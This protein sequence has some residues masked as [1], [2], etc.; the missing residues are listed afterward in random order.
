MASNEPR[1][2]KQ[3]ALAAKYSWQGVRAAWRFEASFRLE[4]YVA[5]VLVPLAP[6]LART[7]LETALLVGSVLLV[8]AMELMNAGLEAIT[9][10]T[11]PE[12]NEL[13]G[14][15]K[16]LGSA[17]VSACMLIALLLWLAVLADR[18]L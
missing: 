14:R 6:W 2:L 5:L 8:M 17:A 1:G 12:F 7:W 13:A 10:K 4:V 9:D 18:W 15:A 3:I 11:T 16:D